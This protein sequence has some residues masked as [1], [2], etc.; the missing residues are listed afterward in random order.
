MVVGGVTEARSASAHR[1]YSGR[2]AARRTEAQ[3]L[4]RL[5]G[6]IS[7]ARLT[8]FVAAIVVAWC[9]VDHH[10]LSLWWLAVPVATFAMLMI[11]HERVIRGRRRFE[12]AVR[13][14][15]R[16]MARLENRWASAGETGERF[17]DPA[18][19][20]AADLDLFGNGSLFQ[21]LCT[22]RTR[23]GEE[24]LAA[25]LC[26]PAAVPEIHARHAAIQEL[27]PRLDLREE[28]AL[29]GADVRAGLHPDALVQWG[30][31]IPVSTSRATRITAAVLVAAMCVAALAWAMGSSALPFA[32]TLVAEA[33]FAAAVRTRVARAIHAVQR[34]GRDLAL[35]AQVLALIE[36][37]QFTSE[38]LTGLRAALDTDGVPPSR[39]IAAL[40][41]LIHLLDAR[42]NQLFA[43]LSG[44]LLWGTQLGLAIEAWRARSGAAIARWLT[45]VGDLEA[46]CAFA[47]YAYEHPADI[48]PEVVEGSPCFEAGGLGHPLIPD[49]RCVRNDVR[50]AASPRLLIVSG[51]NMSGKSTLLRAVGI[52]TVLAL[53]GAPARAQRLRLS[54]VAIGCSIR[55]Q[56]SLQQGT[57][58]FYAEITR[59][60]QLMDI[61][62]GRLPLL[63][64]LDE[65]L[66][67]TNSHDRGIGAAAVARGLLQRGAIGLITTHDLALAHID[68]S[69]DGAANV[70]FEDHLENGR[71]V[72]DYRMRPGVVEKSNAVELMRAVGLE[73]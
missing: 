60:R 4:A 61:A 9:A 25:W 24:T 43:P 3:R 16:G 8:V 11:G 69:L 5:Q 19:P 67:G 70:H 56:D 20:Y 54:P 1:E 14:Y 13:F 2:L 44:L 15:E 72:F 46:F 71:M 52:N 17:L 38:R 36:R 7:Y 49:E 39:Q 27:T 42:K 53:A 58:R 10:W 59:L 73:V 57:S 33:V 41:R 47:A 29:L 65:I 30:E 6:Q 31:R 45:A 48:F 28:L 12:R 35:L 32:A 18:H 21:L 63:F 23:S 51:S 40:H 66:H 34:L 55:I 68:E 50:L 62:S 64:L 37:E 22:A 26:A